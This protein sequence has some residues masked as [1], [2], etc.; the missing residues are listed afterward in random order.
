MKI[1]KYNKL[2]RV[3]I[4][5]NSL[6]LI[7]RTL[8][9]IVFIIYANSFPNPTLAVSIVSVV[10]TIPYLFSF[11]TGYLADR[12]NYKVDAMLIIRI[13]QTIL[14]LVFAV[15]ADLTKDWI[16][17]FF[18]ILI[19]VIS[20]FIGGYTSYLSLSINKYIVPN[21]D[22]SESIGFRNGVNYTISLLG[23]FIGVGTIAVLNHHYLLFGFFNALFFLLS[24]LILFK[25]K[26]ALVESMPSTRMNTISGNFKLKN[27]LSKFLKDSVNNFKILLENKEIFNFTIIFSSM[28]LISSAMTSL[29]L[30]TYIQEEKLIFQSF[31]YTVAL[32]ETFEIV[33]MIIGSTIPLKMYKKKTIEFNLLCEILLFLIQVINILLFKDKYFLLLTVFVSGYLNG[34]SNPRIDTFLILGLPDDKQNSVL[35]IFGTLITLT[36]PVGSI[37]FIFIA[38][39]FSLQ[40]AWFIILIVVS[41]LSIYSFSLYKN[42]QTIPE[43][44]I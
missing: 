40:I 4:T 36:V 11:I 6:G 22:L 33:A 21:E 31:G 30:I 32:I 14:F 20:D 1:F 7:G 43:S 27:Y 15:L 23:G 34:V 12:T 42:H 41:V 25:N 38:N 16:I 26:N 19:N 17:F 3:L 39:F 24:F 9:D 2:Y 5:S 18:I 8:F 29:L 10:T 37:V 28:N 35:S 44:I 13:L